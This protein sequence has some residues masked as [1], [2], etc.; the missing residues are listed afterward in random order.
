MNEVKSESR[1]AG[2]GA[3]GMISIRVG[4]VGNRVMCRLFWTAVD[5][6]LSWVQTDL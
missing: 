3:P 6:R 2:H 4:S 1:D 5:V